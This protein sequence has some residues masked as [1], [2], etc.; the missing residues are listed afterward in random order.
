MEVNI[1]VRFPDMVNLFQAH[2]LVKLIQES[3]CATQEA[4]TATQEAEQKQEP[5]PAPETRKRAP[6]APKEEPK[7]EEPVQEAQ[8]NVAPMP[9]PAAEA[10]KLTARAIAVAGA[11]LLQSNP[12]VQEDLGKLLQQYGL[13]SAMEIKP[14]QMAAFAAAIRGMGAE[15]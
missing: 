10:P 7:H 13:R 2:D 1:N 3:R 11:K 8:I 5:S 15:I 14:E 4:A 9:T 6:V 12:A